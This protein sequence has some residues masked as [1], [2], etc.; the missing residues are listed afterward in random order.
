MGPKRQQTDEERN[1]QQVEA[2]RRRAEAQRLR[3]ANLTDEQRNQHREQNSQTKRNR[4]ANMSDEERNLHRKQNAQSERN[5]VANMSDEQRRQRREN[6]AQNTRNTRQNMTAEQTSLYQNVHNMRLSTSR[7]RVRQRSLAATIA[8]A[9]TDN[10]DETT[11]PLHSCGQLNSVCQFCQA[12]HF[13]S[14]RP[15][16]GYFNICCNKGK[17]FLTQIRQSEFLK[18][19]LTNNHEH[20]KNFMENIRSFNS[21]LAFASMGANIAPPP[22]YGPYA[23]RI[24]GQIYHRAGALNPCNGGQ[25]KFAQ[26]YILDP[27]EASEQRLRMSENSK[28]NPDLMNELSQFMTQQNPFADACKMLHEVE[29]ESIA[30]AQLHGVEPSTVSMAIIQ[31]RNSDLRRYNAPRTN[32]VAV[33]FQNGNGDPP[34]ER[35]L[36]IHCRVTADNPDQ[37][38]CQRINILDPNLEPMTYPLLFPYGDQSWGLNIRLQDRPG[39]LRNRPQSAN[40]RQ[41]VTQMQFYAYRFA[42]RDAFNP[43][44]SAG[45]LTQQYIVDAYVK[46]EAN[47]LNYL[48]QNQKALMAESYQGLIDHIG[49]VAEQQGLNPGKPVILPS[50][51]QG[52]PRNMTQNYLDAMAIVREYGTPDLFITMTCNPK[53]NEITENLGPG[54]SAEFRPD[55]V[56]RVF[57]I[58]LKELLSDI[59]DKHVLGIPIA[60]VHVI[61]FQKR[62]LPHAHM[63]IILKK[64]FKPSDC[65]KID[66]LVCAEI[67]NIETNPRLHEIVTKHM[68]HG[69][70]GVH[71]LNSPCMD[72]LTNE[73]TK[74]FP[75]AFQNATVIEG[76]KGYPLYRRRNNGISVMIKNK[77]ID[78]RWI[79]PYNPSLSL[80]YNCHLNVEVCASI[81]SVKYLFKYVYKGHDCANVTIRE[82]TTLH[83]Y[84]IQ[85]YM[86]SRYVSAPEGA[87]RLF[88]FEMHKQSHTIIRLAVHLPGNQSIVFNPNDVAQ[89]VANNEHRH[90]T[91]TAWFALNSTLPSDEHCLYADTPKKYWFPP[92]LRVWQKRKQEKRGEKVI[93]RMYT[94]SLQDH[95][96]SYYLR[97]ML[98]HVKGATSFENLRTFNGV[99]CDTF[100][101]ASKRMGLLSNDETWDNTMADAVISSMPRQLRE[102]F[103]TICVFACPPN[104]LQLWDKYKEYLI[105]DY[106]RHPNHD[107]DCIQ[108]ENLALRDIQDI[109]IIHGKSCNEFGLRTPPTNIPRNIDDY[110]DVEAE[111]ERGAEMYETLND[112]QKAAFN[113]IIESINCNIPQSRCFFLD[114]PGG[115]GKTYLYKTLLSTV[116][117]MGEVALPVASTG[118]AAN[119]LKGGRTY[120]SQFKLKVPLDETCTSSIRQ[121][122][123]EAELIRR[124]KLIIWDE[125]T[126]A[127]SIALDAVDR[128]LKHL[129]ENNLP[130][131]GKVLLLGGDFRQ[132]LPVVP[133]ASRAAIVESSVK[134]N[135]YW[136]HFKI[137]KL[138]NNVRSEDPEFS[139]WLIDLGNGSL[140]TTEVLPDDVIEIPENMIRT[141]SIVEE[142]FGK[143]LTVQDV[144]KF[145]KM[146]ILCPKNVDVDKI[147]EDV[148]DILEGEKVTYLSSDSIVDET[149]VDRQNYP[150]EFLHDQTSSGM[151][152]HKLNLKIGAIVMLLRNLN[153]KHGLCNGTRLIVKELKP[154]L[155]IAEVLTGPA[156]GNIVFIPRIDLTPSNPDL[157]FTL[158]RRQFPIKLA[159][160]MTI[161]K[162]QGQTLDK[163]GVYLPDPVFSHGQLYVALSRAK[164]SCDVKMKIVDGPLQGKLILGSDK[165]YTKNVFKEIYNLQ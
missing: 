140:P 75:K 77:R 117:G 70:C 102:L 142:I 95:P 84:E 136:E 114:G 56:A 97:L 87:W 151:A 119:L 54:Q 68:I 62:G 96:E 132:T 11:I 36:I 31:D 78:N 1:L 66:K 50:S 118:I 8:T 152:P 165:I 85:T 88:G 18:D 4:I 37:R 12:K 53:W 17:V 65:D 16:D 7:T 30:D 58:K 110:F 94:V 120:H 100:L 59:C 14:E 146:A 153:T 60:H 163:V 148:L 51:C 150:I 131:G 112:E 92:N 149:D 109:F 39:V 101:E 69:P 80:K 21:S 159:F 139:K 147:N 160:A 124:A 121:T 5:R 116:R 156:Q 161:N 134:F 144:H 13:A 133:H 126:M 67:P 86:D 123:S 34:L 63:L 52:S 135:K 76:N 82:E 27:Y 64:E 29:Q 71:N 38:A 3:R 46:T 26:L 89:A 143:K 155:I 127:P 44:L 128:C 162:S 42:I 48:R 49:S 122:S 9:L 81:K 158:K 91:F 98:L 35:D 125:A 103:A 108:C 6:D 104:I 137:L 99:R 40:P 111:R 113:T 79:V 19:L 41:N 130:F 57:K 33:I 83:H 107:A 138:H 32:E 55:L 154:N 25:R 23:F 72:S 164:R 115:S 47:R 105:E 10:F 106:S 145:S 24:H 90:T 28:C 74:K 43:F 20:S 129:M 61:E 15:T 2:K 141:D 93:G 22:G 157:P 73:C 45:K